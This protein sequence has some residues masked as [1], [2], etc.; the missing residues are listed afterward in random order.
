[1]PLPAA[2]PMAAPL[3]VP[4]ALADRLDLVLLEARPDEVEAEGTTSVESTSVEEPAAVTPV[5][6]D[7]EVLLGINTQLAD[8][9]R[10]KAAKVRW[11]AEALPRRPST[12]DMGVLSM[13]AAGA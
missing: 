13:P 6:L 12:V 9:P 7:M 10:S 1:M 11:T 8:L 4:Q 3:R 2:V 5:S